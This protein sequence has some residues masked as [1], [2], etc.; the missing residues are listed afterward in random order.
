M[1]KV[2]IVDDE[3]GTV[4]FIKDRLI[5][6]GHSVDDLRAESEFMALTRDEL[7]SYD[8][9]ILDVMVGTLVTSAEGTAPSGQSAGIRMAR[10]VRV[11]LR[12]PER[13]LRILAYSVV[14]SRE[15]EREIRSF[16]CDYVTKGG[17]SVL[18]RLRRLLGKAQRPTVIPDPGASHEDRR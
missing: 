17:S 15:V 2:L 8:L 16:S 9:I 6:Q 14:S 4:G 5:S 10:H 11:D 7:L 18:S 12:I 13:D 3:R 1:A